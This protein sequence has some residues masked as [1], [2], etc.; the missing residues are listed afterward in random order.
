[1]TYR[2]FID[3]YREILATLPSLNAIYDKYKN[4]EY[5]IQ[6]M[7]LYNVYYQEEIVYTTADLRHAKA[8]VLLRIVE[9]SGLIDDILKRCSRD[10]KLNLYSA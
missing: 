7:E 2:S 4:K 6:K 5:K 9:K 3:T 1:M 8:E 10:D